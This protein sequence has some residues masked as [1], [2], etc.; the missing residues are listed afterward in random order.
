M[1]EVRLNLEIEE[2]LNEPLDVIKAIVDSSAAIE[3]TLLRWVGIARSKGHTWEQIGSALGVT[4][5]SAWERFRDAEEDPDV[6]I[7]RVLGSLPR[8]EGS[9]TLEE[10]RAEERRVDAEIE[11]R[12][13][14][15]PKR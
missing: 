15:K 1:K 10:I 7:R 3:S 8:P 4:R 6:T 5:Q 13:Y 2:G 11:E 14:G 9:P 12:K